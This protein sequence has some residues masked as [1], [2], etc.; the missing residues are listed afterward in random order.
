VRRAGAAAAVLL[1]AGCAKPTEFER[2]QSSSVR[3][4]LE[5]PDSIRVS[6]IDSALRKPGP[7]SGPV[8]YEDSPVIA[9]ATPA[10]DLRSELIRVLSSP[11][12]YGFEGKGCIPDPGVKIRLAR[13]TSV[14]T[15]YFCFRCA[16]VLRAG[17]EP[18][19]SEEHWA[20]FD[21][22]VPALLTIMQKLFPNDEAIRKL[23]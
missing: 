10:G 5:A 22:S 16:M 7:F 6:R 3:A 21:P 11:S 20:D 4:I 9:E 18:V 1:L 17:P 13:R 23:K 19:G 2:F 12:S 14:V 8:A 15:F